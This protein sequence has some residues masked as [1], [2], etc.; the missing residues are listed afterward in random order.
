M[1][2]THA[3]THQHMRFPSYP[4]SVS[5]HVFSS[6]PSH[7]LDISRPTPHTPL[8]HS[9]PPYNPNISPLHLES[10]IRALYENL[11]YIPQRTDKYSLILVRLIDHAD[12]A[13]RIVYALEGRR[14]LAKE[15]GV[16]VC[17]EERLVRLEVLVFCWGEERGGCVERFIVEGLDVEGMCIDL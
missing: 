9:T 16:V 17:R 15:R 13:R 2:Y 3:S 4:S 14:E 7:Q 11:P 12:A 6:Y 5:L 8:P 10:S 1:I